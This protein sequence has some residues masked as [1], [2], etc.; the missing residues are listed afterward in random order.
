MRFFPRGMFIL[1]IEAS[2]VRKSRSQACARAVSA[3]GAAL[4]AYVDE[5]PLT[6]GGLT[7]MVS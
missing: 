6:A 3:A 1:L 4:A 7:L 5:C 2:D